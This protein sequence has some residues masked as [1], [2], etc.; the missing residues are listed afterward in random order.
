MH[1]DV[2]SVG[3]ADGMVP[4]CSSSDQADEVIMAERC[5]SSS[6]PDVLI[7]GGSPSSKME[8][9][10]KCGQILTQEITHGNTTEGAN[11]ITG[12]C[13]GV[14]NLNNCHYKILKLPFIFHDLM[15]ES[16]V[17]ESVWSVESMAP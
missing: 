13:E 3:S 8:R 12:S 5:A 15:T 17:N 6:F 9:A 1:H 2:W 7:G 16:K 11:V 14:T 10:P 4:M